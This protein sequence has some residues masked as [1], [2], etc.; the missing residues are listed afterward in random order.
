MTFSV[1][2]ADRRIEPVRG[3]ACE[4]SNSAVPRLG[5]GH[6]R[7]DERIQKREFNPPPPRYLAFWLRPDTS[8]IPNILQGSSVPGMM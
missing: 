6:E 2:D 7:D 3:H 8:S 4:V 1:A 5:L